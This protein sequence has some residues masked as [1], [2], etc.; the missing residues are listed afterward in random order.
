MDND[1]INYKV[2]KWCI[3]K[4]S[5]KLKNWSYQVMEIL[6]IYKMERF[7]NINQYLLDRN[8]ICQLKKSC[9]ISIKLTVVLDS[10]SYGQG[11]KWRTYKLFK[12][13]SVLNNICCKKLHI[14]HRSSYA[15]FRY[16]AAPFKNETGSFERL[17]NL[18]TCFV[19][20]KMFII[21]RFK[22]TAICP[23]TEQDNNF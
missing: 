4:G 10:L 12:S 17:E 16:W 7:C 21:W 23:H 2:F 3:K 8:T 9:L 15:K 5:H 1:R 11:N 22:A 6:Q 19:T 18:N 13:I 14:R 20:C